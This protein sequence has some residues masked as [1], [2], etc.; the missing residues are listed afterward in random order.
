MARNDSKVKETK[1][2]GGFPLLL[3][4][5][6]LIVYSACLLVFFTFRSASTLEMMRQYGVWEGLAATMIVFL[7]L[8]CLPPALVKARVRKA[9]YGKVC[10]VWSILTLVLTFQFAPV[11]DK[12]RDNGTFVPALLFGPNSKFVNL[13]AVEKLHW[14][15]EWKN[16]PS[17][18]AEPEF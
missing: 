9:P 7:G 10:L 4:L 12:F 2:R 14:G 18:E 3:W 13:V 6:A 11:S 17:L 16:R 5:I 8:L 1:K 15:D